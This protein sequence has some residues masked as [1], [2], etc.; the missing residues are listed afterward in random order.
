MN[1]YKYMLFI[2]IALLVTVQ[3]SF[4]Q[5]DSSD[6]YQTFDSELLRLKVP[7]A[8]Q[9]SS[10]KLEVF[11]DSSWQLYQGQEA[12]SFTMALQ[13]LGLSEKLEQ[14]E[15]YQKKEL[16]Y[17]KQ[18]R[19]RRIFSMLTG[20]GGVGYLAL[21]WN[22]GWVYQIPGYAAMVVAGVRLWESHKIEIQAL[23]EQYYI[24]VLVQ[25]S[26][27]QLLIEDYNFKL[28]QYLTNAGIQFRDT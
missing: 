13:L 17:L 20:I 26:E 16:E 10:L 22:K 3:F 21:I 12:L 25:P 5:T 4:A 2:P 9:K 18:Y 15:Q 7:V 24:Q 23:R 28:Y 11:A 1:I 8:F 19:S 27:I 6:S 14:Y